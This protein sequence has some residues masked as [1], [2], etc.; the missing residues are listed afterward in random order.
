MAVLSRSLHQTKSIDK[1]QTISG[2]E[3]I[4][5]DLMQQV[6]NIDFVKAAAD[7]D[8]PLKDNGE[9]IIESFARSYLVSTEGVAVSD[10]KRVSSKQKLAVVSYF[11]SKSTGPPAFDF[12]SFGHLGGY[13]IGRE[14]HFNKSVKQPILDTFSDNYELF[15]K[16]AGE[17]GGIEKNSGT[18][19]K[20]VWLFQAVPNLLIQTIFYECDEEFPADIQVLFDSKALDLIGLKCLGFL[21]GYFR[22]TLIGAASGS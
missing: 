2:E 14:Q 8:L 6:K 1:M 17:I 7:K 21:P 19:H 4:F 3:K 20:H 15:S 11:L 10:G 5:L 16:A 9:V 12:I 13:N 22:S 18:P